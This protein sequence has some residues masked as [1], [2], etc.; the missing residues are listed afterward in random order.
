MPLMKAQDQAW[1]SVGTCLRA[2]STRSLSQAEDKH[3]YRAR[4]LS[5]LF[6]WFPN[7]P[8]FHLLKICY[9]GRTMEKIK[10]S[11]VTRSWGR[12]GQGKPR[13]FRARKSLYGLLMVETSHW[14]FV[15]THRTC[16]TDCACM[17]HNAQSCPNLCDPVDCSLP[18][19]TVHGIFCQ[20]HWSELPFPPPGDLPN[21][22][23]ETAFPA[24]PALQADPS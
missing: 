12:V 19:S 2:P 17:V 23:T 11:V 15:Q 7:I 18:G 8:V 4:S 1:W 21:P 5:G 9:L 13:T 10:R 16:H 24:S 6:F 14:T 20:E 3:I 22:G